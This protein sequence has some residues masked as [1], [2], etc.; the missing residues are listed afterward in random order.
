MCRLLLLSNDNFLVDSESTLIRSIPLLAITLGQK[1]RMIETR[2]RGL[3]SKL[4][5]LLVRGELGFIL[6]GEGNTFY[7]YKKSQF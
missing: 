1:V 4:P 5:N 2:M 7:E 6:D 3:E